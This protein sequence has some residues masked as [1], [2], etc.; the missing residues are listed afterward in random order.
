MSSVVIIGPA[1]PLRGGL[2]SFNER[3]A[4]EFQTQNFDTTIYTFS[5]TISV[6][7]FSGHITIFNRTCTKR[8]KNKSLYQF[9]QS[10]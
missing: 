8:F 3:L 4:R 6:F 1:H 2:A 10:F 5:L 7:S 9:N